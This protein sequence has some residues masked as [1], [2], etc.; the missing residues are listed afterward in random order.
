M[1]NDEETATSAS[2]VPRVP[3]LSLLSPNRFDVIAKYIY[4]KWRLRNPLA[5]WPRRLYLDHIEVFNGFVEPDGSGKH[6]QAGFLDAFNALIDSIA[7][8]GFD[9]R[10]SRLP[11][12]ATGELVNGAHRLAA[13]LA[14][15]IEVAVATPQGATAYV[16]DYHWFQRRGLTLHWADAIASEACRLLPSSFVI[17]VYPSAVGQDERLE[18]IIAARTRIWYRKHIELTDNGAL[19]LIQQI[20]RHEPWVG[21]VHNDFQGARDKKNWCF[22]RQGLMRVYLVESELGIIRG[23][24]NEIRTIFGIDNHS[25][26]INDTHEEARE[27]AGLLF[28]ENSIHMLNMRRRRALPCFDVLFP[29]Y[30]KA[31]SAAPAKDE[32]CVDGSSVL[33]AYGM[34]DVG[35]IDFM[36]GPCSVAPTFSVPEISS[37]NDEAHQYN[38][39]PES[40][41]HDPGL[42][43]QFDNLKFARL[44]LV[45]SM[46]ARRGEPKDLADVALIDDWTN[47]CPKTSSLERTGL[48]QHMS[49]RRLYQHI[50]YL[51]LRLRLWRHRW[52]V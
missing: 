50:R 6:G 4:A 5:D 36:H 32:F 42:H 29:V 30:A 35:D 52:G 38:C 15:G 2:D 45:R 31:L 27:L 10:R 37:H 3:A 26:H 44:D 16:Y 34:R 13:S 39:T 28:N 49:W 22:A 19:N 20:Y 33:A 21:E 24:K 43:F 8:D 48:S 18:A 23:L 12:S 7:M 41:V 11:V 40:M 9:E 46:K 17:V 25:V 51:K 14:L 47:S 1:R